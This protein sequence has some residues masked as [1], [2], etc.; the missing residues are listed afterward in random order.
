MQ[1]LQLRNK[2]NQYDGDGVHPG[3]DPPT[4]PES[5]TS[6]VLPATS[7]QQMQQQKHQDEDAGVHPPMLPFSYE[8]AEAE[9]D[10]AVADLQFLHG[11]SE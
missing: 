1:A 2:K 5:V 10:S 6:P 3:L 8:S 4:T 7:H 9:Q 11:G